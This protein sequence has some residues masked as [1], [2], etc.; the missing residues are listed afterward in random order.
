MARLKLPLYV[1][2]PEAVVDGLMDVLH[3]VSSK[4]H[5]SD[6]VKNE[7]V[8]SLLLEVLIEFHRSFELIKIDVGS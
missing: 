6:D 3:T 7:R 4:H 5:S 2:N 1:Q 8:S